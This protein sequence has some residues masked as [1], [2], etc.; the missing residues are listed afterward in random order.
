MKEVMTVPVLTRSR[1]AIRVAGAATAAAPYVREV[2]TDPDLRE[3]ARTSIRSLARVYDEVAADARLRDRVFDKAREA[4]GATAE[5]SSR[6]L[7]ISVSPRFARW[8]ILAMGFMA[9]VATI[10]A[11]LAYPRSRKRVSRAV[12]D[13]RHGVVSLTGRV[14]KRTPGSMEE[15]KETISSDGSEVSEAA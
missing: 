9:G 12:V 2:A 5:E 1:Q 10:I 3:A 15:D 4:A 6:P 13:A 11:V 8:G 14:R 7:R